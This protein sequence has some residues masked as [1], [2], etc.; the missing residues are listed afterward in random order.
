MHPH[1]FPVHQRPV[2]R[3]SAILAVVLAMLAVVAS[4]QPAVAGMRDAG[5]MASGTPIAALQAVATKTPTP[6]YWQPSLDELVGLMEAAWSRQD[7]PEVLHLIERIRA[8]DPNREGLEERRYFAYVNYGYQLMT[9]GRCTE[10]RWAFEQALLVR[11]QGEEALMGLDLLVRYCGTP[12]PVSPTP[13]LPTVTLTP[14]PPS[15]PAP[16]P[17]TYVVQPGDTLFG[18]SR[19]FGVTVQAIMSANGLMSSQLY[20]GQTL[21]IPAGA[22]STPGP[23]V[24][25]VQP[26]ETLAAIARRYNTTVWA[27]MSANGLTSHTI[28]AYR[29]LFIPTAS[30]ETLARHVVLRGE[31]LFS[32]AQR[33]GT[34]VALLMLANNLPDYDLYV[35]Q[36]LIIPPPGWS[37]WPPLASGPQRL[38]HL[39][40]AG[41]TLFAIARRYGVTV[42]ALMSANGLNSTTIYAGALLWIP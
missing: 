38:S 16:Q 41:E 32:I 9:S 18:L 37:G 12:T 22:T 2:R 23:L 6:Q 40:A 33:Y 20:S 11:P 29:A 26:G 34:T 42:G 15:H 36:T 4:A 35:Y 8:L 14:T 39:V 5:A 13:T 31:T 28:W 7:W 21:T 30:P 1:P 17:F 27:I 3:R 10:A 24:H 19:R 25:I